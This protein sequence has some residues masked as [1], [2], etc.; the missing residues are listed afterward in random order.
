MMLTPFH[1]QCLIPPDAIIIYFSA[2]DASPLPSCHL[3]LPPQQHAT[4]FRHALSLLTIN[5]DVFHFD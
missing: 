4:S 3:M 2:I 1:A 5:A